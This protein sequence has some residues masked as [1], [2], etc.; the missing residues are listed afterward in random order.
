V[1]VSLL[2][3][4]VSW[5]TYQGQGY[6]AASVVP[7]PLG[8]AHPSI[9]PYQCFEASDGYLNLAVG[10]DGQWMRLCDALDGAIDGDRWYRSERYA[11]NQERVRHRDELVAALTALFS[12][13]PRRDWL[14]LCERAGVP[15]GNVATLD[16]VF[17][18]PQIRARGLVQEVEHP[19]VGR[20]LGRIPM[21]GTPIALSHAELAETTAPPLLGED[22]QAVLR[23]LGYDDARIAEVTGHGE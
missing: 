4:V 16:E 3:T 11:T 14:E 2:E 15:A 9:V 1:D 18:N 13:R 23:S 7:R 6:L 20:I 5:H 8:S 19:S 22:S 12:T 10:N 17:D 21:V